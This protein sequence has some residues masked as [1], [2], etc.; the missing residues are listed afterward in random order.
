[1]ADQV[2]DSGRIVKAPNSAIQAKVDSAG[3]LKL[4][5]EIQRYI[6]SLPEQQLFVTLV[7][8]MAQLYAN[9]SWERNLATLSADTADPAAAER[10]GFLGAHYGSDV[11][12][13]S[14]GR[15]TLPQALRAKLGMQD[16]PVVLRMI[17]D[18]IKVYR[19]REYEEL[20]QAAE[21]LERQDLEH[22]R[23]QGYK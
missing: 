2:Q 3:R 22:F 6:H 10:L 12:M 20:R 19:Q 4:P 11:V 18:V 1:M 7:G 5:V 17:N 21:A 15:V 9:S 13:D 14:Q 8:G 16:E 23:R